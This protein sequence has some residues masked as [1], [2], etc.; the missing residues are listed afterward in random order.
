MKKLILETTAPFQGLPDWSLM[1][2]ACS[3]KKGSWSNGPT[4]RRASRKSRDPRDQPE[5][6]RSLRQPWQVVRAGQGGHVYNAC[7]WG[8][9]CVCRRRAQAAVS[10]AAERSSPTPPWWWRPI[11]R[12]FTPQQ[13]AAAPSACR[14]ISAPTTSRCTCWKVS[15]RARR[16]SYAA[17]GT[18]AL[19]AR[20]ADE[21]E[22]EATTL[23]EPHITLAEKKGCRTICTAFF[24][25]TEVASDRV[26]AKTYAAFNRAVREAVRRINADKR[27]YLHYFIDI[28]PKRIRR[29]R[30]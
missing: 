28:T 7:E 22:I 25:G 13:L 26:D 20:R 19:P 1:T 18:L 14:S 27:A 5:R 30:R 3:R 21:G 17:R 23:T 16:S 6:S 9:Y 15:C 8:N 12:L 24:H 11:R 2:R 4:A 29:L 10:S